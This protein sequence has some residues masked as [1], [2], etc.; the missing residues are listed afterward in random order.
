MALSCSSF[1]MGVVLPRTGTMADPKTSGN[2]A[3][4]WWSNVWLRAAVL[5]P[6]LFVAPWAGVCL[7]LA[8]LPGSD[9]NDV[10]RGF[11]VIPLCAI[12]SF[13]TT[14]VMAARPSLTTANRTLIVLLG[15]IASGAAFVLGY[16]AWF[17]A[18][19]VAC[20]GGYECPL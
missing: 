14:A 3:R 1:M 20:H 5:H 12:A 17:H 2:G 7:V 11:W 16:G 8:A 19:D 6:A 13:I 15:L 18:A 9:I 4:R 10:A